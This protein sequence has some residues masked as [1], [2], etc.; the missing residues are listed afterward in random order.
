MPPFYFLTFAKVSVSVSKKIGLNKVSVSVSKT[1]GLKNIWSRKKV[2][3]LV[4]MKFFGLVTQCWWLPSSTHVNINFT[5]QSSKRPKHS[6]YVCGFHQL[7]SS[8]TVRLLDTTFLVHLHLGVGR[9]LWALTSSL[10]HELWKTPSTNPK[11]IQT[12]ASL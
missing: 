2:S 5:T 3:V 1:F 8:S 4:S 11:S 10:L 9:E 6:E 7:L 12:K